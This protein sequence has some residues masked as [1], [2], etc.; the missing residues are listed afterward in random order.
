MLRSF[1]RQCT[2]RRSFQLVL[3][4]GGGAGLGGG[5]DLFDL[6]GGDGWGGVAEVGADVGEDVGGLLVVEAHGG[7]GEGGELFELL[8]V[9]LDGAA[10]AVEDD[11]DEAG[12]VA[13]GPVGTGDAGVDAGETFAFGL[14]A[15]EAEG[16][17][18]GLARMGDDG[19]GVGDLFHVFGLGGLMVEGE[20]GEYGL[21]L[22]LEGAHGLAEGVVEKL[23]HGVVKD[24]GGDF[25]GFR[26]GDAG[27]G[28]DGFQAHA[29]M[30]IMGGAGELDEG[31]GKAVGPGTGDARAVGTDAGVFGGQQA[32]KEGF[33]DGFVGFIHAADFHELMLVLGLGDV[34]VGG[35]DDIIG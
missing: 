31:I 18:N 12:G 16:V 10:E 35:G 7:H 5:A 22:G 8:A 21:P 32:D 23:V 25:D 33:V 2:A 20:G 1:Q 3:G 17:I 4:P 30:V 19:G 9:H 28:D 13:G 11:F 15:V 6:V 24:L 34:F 14:V 27:G 26:L 29:R